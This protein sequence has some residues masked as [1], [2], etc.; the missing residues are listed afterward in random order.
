MEIVGTCCK[1]GQWKQTLNECRSAPVYFF[2][3]IC[4][5][6]GLSFDKWVPGIKAFICANEPRWYGC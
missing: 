3:L 6:V 4:L 2:V 5:C 1:V